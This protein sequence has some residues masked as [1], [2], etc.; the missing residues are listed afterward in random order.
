MAEMLSSKHRIV[1]LHANNILA[2]PHAKRSPI[3]RHDS[4][5]RIARLCCRLIAIS[6]RPLL[7]DDLGEFL[8]VDLAVAINIDF[9]DDSFDI[10]QSYL[11]GPGAWHLHW[12]TPARAARPPRRVGLKRE[13][14][15]RVRL[16]GSPT[17][18]MMRRISSAEMKPSPDVSKTANA[19]FSVC[20][21]RKL[22]F[23]RSPVGRG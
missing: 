4:F 13:N 6:C 22:T 2:R 18:I 3:G 20:K 19:A 23:S 5:P 11:T 14:Y 16:T 1:R 9:S 10:F 8:V 21:G 12:E 15:D 17:L 7:N